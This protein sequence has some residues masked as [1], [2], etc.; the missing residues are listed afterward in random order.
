MSTADRQAKEAR[1]RQPQMLLQQQLEQQRLVMEV[2]QRIRRSL[3]V[4]DILQTTVEEVRQ[5][6]QTDRVIILQFNNHWQGNIVVES[7]GTEWHAIL[8]A[9]IQDSCFGEGYLE[10]FRQGMVTVKSNIY[11]ADL[12]ACH[13]EFLEGFQVKANLVV[14]LLH[15]EE[16]WGLLVAH[17]CAA[18]REWQAREVDLLQQ[19][20]A[21]ISIA[22]QQSTLFAQGQRE[23]IQRQEAELSLQQLNAELEQRVA[24]RTREL[25]QV[26]DR[27]LETLLDQ[28]HTQ[29]ILQEQAQLLDL[30]HDTIMTH[31]LD[32]VITFWNQGAEF[33]YG[34]TNAEA[35]GQE[36]H[37]LLQ[38]QFPQPLAE[39]K[40]QLQ[41][42]GYWEGELLHTRRDGLTITVNS[43][44]VMQKDQLGKPIKVLE[45][46]NN[47]SERKQ[48]EADLQRQ[49]LQKQLLWNITQSVRQSLDIHAVLN[50]AVREV[51]QTLEVDRVS[52]YTALFG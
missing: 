39:I 15:G 23:I 31:D 35:L 17:H 13:L 27:L 46:N 19:L 26:N 8:S 42:Q 24:E 20:A 5:F 41:A 16:L 10:L 7:V 14:P 43:R 29:V 18:P 40:A 52:V 38:T 3:N 32:D 12:T 2:S 51:H 50:T 1:D 45:I 25:T 22:L 48:A 30:A 36:T 34:W 9:Q 47:I 4:A 49:M 28:Q 37:L 21:Q 6:L 33:M 11:E 44:W